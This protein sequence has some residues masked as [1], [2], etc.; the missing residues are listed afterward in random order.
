MDRLLYTAMSGARQLM[1]AQA[2]NSHN[3]AN[4]ST[5]GFRA[6]LHAA[7]QSVVGGAG[8][9]SRVQ[10]VGTGLGW[11]QAV[12]P[13]THTGR[14]LDVAVQG[15]GFIAVQARD[16]GEGYT[17]AGD[18]RVD[19]NGI[20]RTGAGLAVLGDGGAPIAVPPHT[21]IHVGEDGTISVIPLGQDASTMAVVDRV[22]LVDPDPATLTKGADG[23]LRA[24][25]A[26]A[27]P[28]DAAVRL[29]AGTLEGSNVNA[30]NALVEM[31]QIARQ[32]E[33]QVKLMQTVEDNDRRSS[34]L[35]RL[36]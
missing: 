24:A 7:T 11:D 21:T 19:E 20:L 25:G 16:G 35:L 9:P 4:V 12:G 1:E 6:D 22:R 29:R 13:Q 28:A 33:M 26:D 14:D 17:R 2:V 15:S 18:L 23:L 30:A 8:L 27:P 5:V 10:S 34:Q 31:I 32:Y 36:G 3:L